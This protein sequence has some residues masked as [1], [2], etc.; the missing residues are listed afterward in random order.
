[1]Q[2]VFPPPAFTDAEKSEQMCALTNTHVAQ[3]AIGAADLGMLKLL[4]SFGL[5][6]AMVAGHSYGEYVAL[7]AAG[8]F[9]E[10]DLFK[11]S[12]IRGQYS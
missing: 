5:A 10:S 7:H 12:E 1:M 11:I 6:P 2:S 9:S 4:R 8:V 3:P